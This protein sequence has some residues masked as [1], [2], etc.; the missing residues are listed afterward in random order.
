MLNLANVPFNLSRKSVFMVY[1]CVFPVIPWKAGIISYLHT[2][3]I[4]AN[5]FSDSFHFSDLDFNG[6][7]PKS[8]NLKVE[9]LFPLALLI[10]LENDYF[11]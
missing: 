3:L 11:S 10:V 9:S 5:H 7:I 6:R 8:N 4:R 1:N 2:E